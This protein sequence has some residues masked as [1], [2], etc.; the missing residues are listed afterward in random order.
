MKN[1]KLPMIITGA[2]IAFGATSA[3]AL[4]F[5]P[6]AGVGFG[7]GEAKLTDFGGLVESAAKSST[8]YSAFVGAE[9]LMFRIE[10]EYDYINSDYIDYQTVMANGYIE[11]PIPVIKPYFGLGVGVITDAKIIGGFVEVESNKPMY[12]VMAGVEVDAPVLPFAFDVEGRLKTASNLYTFGPS[13]PDFY[14]F[15]LRGKVKYQF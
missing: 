3:N 11:M 9:I 7:V 6:Y 8:S 5:D 2:A 15:E 13:S 12:Q 10:A 1:L 4:I 14:Q